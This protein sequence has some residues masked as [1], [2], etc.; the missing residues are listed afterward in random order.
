MNDCIN[1]EIRDQL[2]DLVHDRLSAT[3]RASVLAHVE[4]CADCGDELQLL[5]DAKAMFAR[6][7]PRVDVAYVV[8]ALPKAP[9]RRATTSTVTR[10]E[11]ARRTRTWNDWRVAA[12]V[13]LLIAGGGSYA[14][15]GHKAGAAVDS[16][17]A[18]TAPASTPPTVAMVADSFAGSSPDLA[19]LVVP[20]DDTPAS[21]GSMDA[22]LGDLNEDQLN[23]LLNDMDN[24]RAVPA[25]EPEPVSIRVDGNTASEDM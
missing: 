17:S 2:P 3:D 23:A 16:G 21:V 20:D 18:V 7:I 13:T 6:G 1:A 8:G 14:V 12:A 22:R 10:L 11:P 15:M 5:R 19:A 24:L 9:A 4:A 25:S